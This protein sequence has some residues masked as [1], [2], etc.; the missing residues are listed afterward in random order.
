MDDGEDKEEDRPNKK[1]KNDAGVEKK[2][3][4]S[5]RDG[6]GR[7]TAGRTAWKEKHRKG[8][9]SGKKRLSERKHKQPLGI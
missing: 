4:T 6:T 2:V 1:P 9:F 3:F 5:T 8:K 7:S